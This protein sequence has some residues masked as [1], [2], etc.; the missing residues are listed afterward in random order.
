[1]ETRSM[2]LNDLR[3]QWRVHAMYTGVHTHIPRR[4]EI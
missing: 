4:L 1:M 2:N 3:Q